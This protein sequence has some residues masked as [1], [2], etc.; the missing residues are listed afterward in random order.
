MCGFHDAHAAQKLSYLRLG[1]LPT[2][3]ER[4]PHDRFGVAEHRT[5]TGENDTEDGS[6]MRLSYTGQQERLSI[7]QIA[8]DLEVNRNT[9]REYIDDTG[10]PRRT[11][12]SKRARP[13]L[14]EH[15]GTD[16]GDP[17]GV[18][19]AHL[20]QAAYHRDAGACPAPRGGM[21]GGQHDGAFLLGGATP[22]AAGSVVPLILA[23]ERR[24]AGGLRVHLLTGAGGRG[25]S[26]LALQLAAALASDAAVWSVPRRTENERPPRQPGSTAVDHPPS[27]PRTVDR[28]LPVVLASWEDEAAEVHRRLRAQPVPV[29]PWATGCTTWTAPSGDRFGH[30]RRVAGMCRPSPN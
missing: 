22:P 18:E 13:V 23:P 17:G 1:D 25:K 2:C 27:L 11:A 21:P 20:R 15:A 24:G 28:G 4:T 14:E 19:L 10:E 26:R 29:E 3:G 9:V 8:R 6:R 16:R 7:R 5:E 12:R 30:R